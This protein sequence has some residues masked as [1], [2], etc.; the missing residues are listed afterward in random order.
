MFDKVTRTFKLSSGTSIP[1]VGAGFGTKWCVRES[2]E[3]DQSVVIGVADAIK[4][5]FTHLD[6]AEFYNTEREMGQGIEQTG[7]DRSKLFIT[8]KVSKSFDNISGALDTMLAKLKTNYVDL[9]LLHSPFFETPSLEQAWKEMESL[10]KSGKARAIGVSNFRV[11]DLEKLL[12][13]AEI[14]PAVNQIEYSA[15]MQNQSP[16]IVKF[17]QDNDILV[18]AYSPLQPIIQG[19]GKEA[20]TSL[21]SDI[22]KKYN[23]AGG[24][25]LLRWVLQRNVL[26]ITASS[27]PE[28]LA[29]ALDIFDFELTDDEMNAISSTG[30]KYEHRAHWVGFY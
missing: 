16:H 3:P 21:V 20:M 29:Q 4:C 30:Q 22:G 13:V 26:P 25:V 2:G 14:P 17:C 1:A 28:R 15:C 24:Q 7:T 10:Q 12:N 23:K 27:K 11:R 5:G 18:Q 6:G 9:Y 8:T 19:P